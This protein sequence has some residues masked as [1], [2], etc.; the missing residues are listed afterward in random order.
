MTN[1]LQQYFPMIRTREEVLAEIGSKQELE[2]IFYSWA[3][4]QREEFLDFCTGVRG[5]KILYDFM[6][7]EILDPFATPERAEELLSLFLGRKVKILAVLP[8]DG[9]RI[10]D[11]SSLLIMDMVVELEDGSICNVE[12]QKIGYKFPGQRS[13]CYSADLLLRQYKRTRSTMKK[14]FSYK[15]I[16]SV[17]TI[18]LFERSPREFHNYPH[19]WLHNFEQKSDTGL[20]LK[21]LQKYLFVPL[22]IF[23]ENQYNKAIETKLDAWLAFLCMD[24]PETVIAVSKDYPEFKAMYEQVYDICRNVEAVMGLFSKELQEL[25][26]NTVQLMIDEM[27]ENLNQAEAE[28]QKLE[29]EKQKAEEEA[30]KYRAEV[31]EKERVYQALL[32]KMKELES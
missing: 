9:T 27:Q 20:E 15:Q 14:K 8:N 21:L 11:E 19:I 13:A 30:A 7:K 32:Q 22:D 10:A 17:Y 5:V 1:K 6:S 24:D 26:R 2:K 28:I 31:D 25:D 16:K 29:I 23:R 18:V 3:D 4:E 12:I